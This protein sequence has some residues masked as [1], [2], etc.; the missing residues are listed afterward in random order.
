[1]EEE[2]HDLLKILSLLPVQ[3]ALNPALLGRCWGGK[4]DECGV[5]VGGLLVVC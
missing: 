5:F 2:L 3:R 4:F 1:M